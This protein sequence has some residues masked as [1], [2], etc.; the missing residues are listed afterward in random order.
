M[1]VNPLLGGQAISM[2]YIPPRQVPQKREASGPDKPVH[3]GDRTRA[4]IPGRQAMCAPFLRQVDPAAHICLLMAPRRVPSCRRGSA[5]LHASVQ[6]FSPPH[7]SAL[8]TRVRDTHRGWRPWAGSSSSPCVAH[9]RVA[10]SCTTGF[11]RR[12]HSSALLPHAAGALWACSHRLPWHHLLQ[13][14]RPQ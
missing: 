11:H 12:S 6:P 7:P 1:A 13:G 3:Q 8:H 14:P 4:P 10:H 9:Y 5:H 2:W